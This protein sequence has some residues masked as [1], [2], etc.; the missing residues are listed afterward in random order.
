MTPRRAKSK[1]EHRVLITSAAALVQGACEEVYNRRC[2]S[3]WPRH[4]HIRS[5]EM[6]GFGRGRPG[7]EGPDN[8][9]CWMWVEACCPPRSKSRGSC[10]VGVSSCITCSLSGCRSLEGSTGF[11]SQQ[12]TPPSSL[13]Y[14]DGTSPYF[15][16]QRHGIE[17]N[18]KS[19]HTT[20]HQCL[21]GILEGTGPQAQ[22]VSHR[23]QDKRGGGF[24]LVYLSMSA[25]VCRF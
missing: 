11:Q 1:A 14:D 16:P 17:A 4:L 15:F 24:A 20:P 9:P 3:E 5:E 21:Q 2:V 18:S 8:W 6:S 23:T 13:C 19:H 7:G 12:G 25:S 10:P 22:F